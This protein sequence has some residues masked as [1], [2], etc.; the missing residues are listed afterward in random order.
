MNAANELAASDVALRVVAANV[1]ITAGVV[2]ALLVG[3]ENW[4]FRVLSVWIGVT[5]AT[6]WAVGVAERNQ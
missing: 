2:L 4:A 1:L 5:L 3:P 6:V